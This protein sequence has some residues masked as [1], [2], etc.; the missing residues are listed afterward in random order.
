[1]IEMSI[2]VELSTLLPVGSRV[3]EAKL[4]LLSAAKV[5]LKQPSGALSLERNSAYPR[6]GYCQHPPRRALTAYRMATGH[7]APTPGLPMVR[8]S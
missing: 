6:H 5:R 1:M 3:R 7:Q 4:K 8:K 2:I